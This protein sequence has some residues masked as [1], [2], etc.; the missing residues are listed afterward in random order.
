MLI[1]VIHA[2]GREHTSNNTSIT[3][4]L[5]S[6]GLSPSPRLPIDATLQDPQVPGVHIPA[7]YTIVLQRDAMVSYKE[8][9]KEKGATPRRPKTRLYTEALTREAWPGLNTEYRLVDA[10][11]RT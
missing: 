7:L 5:Q 6:A 8:T 11:A 4:V 3:R 1:C 2:S 10:M 9:K